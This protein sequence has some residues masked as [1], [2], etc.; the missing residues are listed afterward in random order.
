MTARLFF[1]CIQNLLNHK[2]WVKN[3]FFLSILF[4]I[5]FLGI[6]LIFDQLSF[7]C[8]LY[9]KLIW[10]LANTSQ[11]KETRKLMYVSI[12]RKSSIFLMGRMDCWVRTTA[13]FLVYRTGGLDILKFL[14]CFLC[15]FLSSFASLNIFACFFLFAEVSSFLEF[16]HFGSCCL[17]CLDR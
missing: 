15:Y 4:L 8:I 3:Y 5:R 10:I 12:T 11:G 7:L 17:F 2:I 1:Y 16:N 14:I 13:G 6:L 9:V